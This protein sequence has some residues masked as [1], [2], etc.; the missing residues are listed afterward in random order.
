MQK[1]QIKPL[2][3][4]ECDKVLEEYNPNV[5]YGKVYASVLFWIE[6]N[7]NNSKEILS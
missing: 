5:N 1:L 6:K 2:S 4:S 3:I 7:K